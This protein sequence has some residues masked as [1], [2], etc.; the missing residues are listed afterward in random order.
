MTR[1]SPLNL[2][3][4]LQSKEYDSYGMRILICSSLY[5]MKTDWHE[6]EYQN[7]RRKER[8]A[9]ESRPSATTQIL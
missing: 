3:H 4:V 1:T 7:W 8:H 6:Y 9:Q 2:P 5:A